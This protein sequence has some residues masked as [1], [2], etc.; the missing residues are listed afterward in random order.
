MCNSSY[1]NPWMYNGSPFESEQI[2]DNY[3]FVYKIT[4]IFDGTSYIGKKFFWSMKSQVGKTRRKRTES[5]WKKYWSSSELIKNLVREFGTDMFKREIIS[6][7]KT[8]GQTN[9]TEVKVQFQ[10]DVLEARLHSGRRAFYN[11]NI[12][13]RYFVPRSCV[14]LTED[15]LKAEIEIYMAQRG[16]I[17]PTPKKKRVS[18]KVKHDETKETLTKES[19]IKK[20]ID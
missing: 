19:N 7:H 1:P 12:A 18:K 9:Y 5:N 16:M 4:N 10:L 2:Q 6:L 13:S 14:Q 11:D 17:K 15:E 8:A 3:G 20:S